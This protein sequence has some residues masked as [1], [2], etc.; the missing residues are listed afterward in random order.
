MKRM[1]RVGALVLMASLALA[2]ASCKESKESMSPTTLANMGGMDGLVKYMDAWKDS[3]SAN[4][5]LSKTLTADDQT[6]VTRG[7]ANEVAKAGGIPT[8]NAGVDL[9]QVLEQKHLS[10]DDLKAMGDALHSAAKG[11]MLSPD[12]TKAAMELWENV[13]KQ[14]K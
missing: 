7:F 14:V 1:R 12:A 11:N 4:P 6:M 8:P 10:K 3:M 2:A 9:K 5:T 13:A